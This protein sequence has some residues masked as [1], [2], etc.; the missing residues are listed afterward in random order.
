[1]IQAALTLILWAFALMVATIALLMV[2]SA[3]C[4]MAELAVD[5]WYLLRDK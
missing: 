5:T 2:W 3:V 4:F 1:M